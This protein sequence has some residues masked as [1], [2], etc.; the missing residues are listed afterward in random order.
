MPK[1]RTGSKP[2]RKQKP[3]AERLV[4]REYITKEDLGHYLGGVAV[5]TI[6]QWMTTR[7]L[8]YVKIGSKFVRFKR[9]EVDTWIS[10]YGGT[11]SED[12]EVDRIVTDILG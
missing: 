4:S 10:Q 6:N 1:R 12:D 2:G 8:P 3:A 7:Q 5:R 11:I 9:S